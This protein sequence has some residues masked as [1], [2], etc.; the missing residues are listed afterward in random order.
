VL[1]VQDTGV[2]LDPA[3]LPHVFDLFRQGEG[4]HTGQHGGLG[5]GLALVRQL[6]DL[7]GGTVVAESDGPGTGATFTV[8]LPAANVAVADTA[9]RSVPRVLDGVRVLLVEDDQEARELLAAVLDAAGASVT[10]VGTTTAAME[11]LDTMRFELMVSDFNRQAADGLDL[12][13]AARGR[14]HQLPAV[15][16]SA[17]ATAGDRQRVAEAGYALHIAKPVFP[18]PFVEA[19]ASVV[20]KAT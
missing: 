8:T 17:F 4:G 9:D 2:G 7:H 13:K 1:K 18:T 16:V 11:A 19:L 3:F 6:V 15:A 12:L 14:G 10:A 5:L 20:H